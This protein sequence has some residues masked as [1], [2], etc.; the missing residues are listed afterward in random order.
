M[1]NIH[2]RL[3]M[4]WWQTISSCMCSTDVSSLSDSVC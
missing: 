4:W 2:D 3:L 1:R